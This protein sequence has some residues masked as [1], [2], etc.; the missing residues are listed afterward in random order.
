MYE[1]HRTRM[2]PLGRLAAGA[3]VALAAREGIARLRERDLRGKVTLITGGSRGLGLAMARAFA[4]AGCI[5]ALCARDEGELDRAREDLER[6]GAEAITLAGDVSVQSDMERVVRETERI[7]GP[8]DIL[9]NNAGII[10]VGPVETVTPQDI[11]D[12]LSTMLWGTVYPIWEVLPR[13]QARRSGHIVNITSLGGK[14]SIPHL[15]PYSVAKFAAV[16]LSEGLRAE[17]AKDGVGVTTVVPGLMR[18]GS[19][20][21]TRIKGQRKKEFGLFS[22]MANLPLFSIS[23]ESAAESVVRAVKRNSAEVVL[24]P[25]GKILTLFHGVF[26]GAT[27]DILGVVSAML[28]KADCSESAPEPGARIEAEL[29]HPRLADP[30]G[31][32]GKAARDLNET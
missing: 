4:D 21:H 27:A 14:V 2:S 24:S 12:N 25:Q 30:L 8:I 23:A 31:L 11:E 13:M 15:L 3:A 5:L 10:S 32:G 16:G 29:A 18:T 7:L 6:R 26:P 1:E 19:Y 28:P 17:L 22:A 9:V 20:L